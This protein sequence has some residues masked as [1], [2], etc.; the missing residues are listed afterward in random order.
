MRNILQLFV[1]FGGL[2]LFILLEGISL[3]MVVQFNEKQEQIFFYS[4]NKAVG[5]FNDWYNG[6]MDYFRLD[7]A[8][9]EL[10]EE[11]A[12]LRTQLEAY[13][14]SD[15]INVDT[16]T[17]DSTKFLYIGADV[18][19][20]T[21][22]GNNNTLTLDKGR[23]DGIGKHMGV[24]SPRGVVGIVTNASA[25]YAGVMTILHKESRISASIKRSGYFGS[26]VWDGKDPMRAALENLPRH[27]SIQIG[28]TIQT[29][30]YSNI[31]PRG[32]MIGTVETFDIKEG[33][34]N[35]SVTV[36]LSND[37]CNI[38]QAYVI[39]NR[40]EDELTNLETN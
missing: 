12:K 26:L 14:F 18:I 19:N 40:D 24:V 20:K 28:D 29:S 31:F 34:D 2:F 23:T 16:L 27:A 30:G 6:L 17:F 15:E 32:I 9:E 22:L 25:E 8:I 4:Y 10:R 5:S 3:F 39:I 1:R 13:G 21:I 37:I 33:A 38:Q 11:N 35:Y 7:K 36:K